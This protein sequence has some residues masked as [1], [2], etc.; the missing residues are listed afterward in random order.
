VLAVALNRQFVSRTGGFRSIRE[1]KDREFTYHIHNIKRRRTCRT[2][3]SRWLRRLNYLRYIRVRSDVY[4]ISEQVYEARQGRPQPVFWKNT[5]K[6]CTSSTHCQRKCI[7]QVLCPSK[8]ILIIA[9]NNELVEEADDKLFTNVMYLKQH[10]LHSTFPGTMD[11]KY[12]LRPRR[13][14]FKLTAKNS[15]IAECDFFYQDAF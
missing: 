4:R 5:R 14:N 10:V 11:T 8:N 15:S 12:H 9:W 7:L 2:H 3:L 13:H 6:A 1:R